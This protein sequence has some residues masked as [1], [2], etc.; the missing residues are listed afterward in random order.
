MIIHDLLFW[1]CISLHVVKIQNVFYCL[2]L[3]HPTVLLMVYTGIYLSKICFQNLSSLNCFCFWCNWHFPSR[4]HGI[5]LKHISILKWH[6]RKY[7]TKDHYILIHCLCL[8]SYSLYGILPDVF[9]VYRMFFVC[10][11]SRI[12]LSFSIFFAYLSLV[13]TDWKSN[14]PAFSL[15]MTHYTLRKGV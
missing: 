1:L 10:V 2:F 14:F 5:R 12:F 6:F 13:S 15:N 9:G 11:L 8:E 3:T 4:I 7:N